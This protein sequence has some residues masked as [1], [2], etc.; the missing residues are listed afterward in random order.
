MVEAERRRTD[1]MHIADFDASSIT[2]HALVEDR[3]RMAA[4]EAIIREA[5]SGR[6]H[7]RAY[8]GAVGHLLIRLGAWLQAIAAQPATMEET[9][10]W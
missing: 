3:L 1:M 6:L 4:R 9:V 8:I 2:A 7:R 5:R 10:Q